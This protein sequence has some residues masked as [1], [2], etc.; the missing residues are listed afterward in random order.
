MIVWLTICI[1]SE[2]CGQVEM[3]YYFVYDVCIKLWYSMAIVKKDVVS[4]GQ[5]SLQRKKNIYTPAPPHTFYNKT[6]NKFHVAF[7]LIVGYRILP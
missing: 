3:L 1:V 2:H 6:L 4:Y 5:N 7:Q